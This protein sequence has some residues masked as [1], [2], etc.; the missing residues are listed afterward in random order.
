[1]RVYNDRGACI[2]G[3]VIDHSLMRDVVLIPTGAWLDPEFDDNGDII[4]CH[5]G[6][7]NMLT[8]DRPTSLLGQGP[9]ANSC[10]VNIEKTLPPKT[11]KQCFR[12][13]KIIK[14]T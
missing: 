11:Q 6:N 10:L 13:P 8:P 1:M 5:H 3:A 14:K 7:P 2:C 9:A 4:C 12:P